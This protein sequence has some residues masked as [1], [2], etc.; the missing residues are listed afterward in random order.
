MDWSGLDSE[1]CA[2]ATVYSGAPFIHFW[3]VSQQGRPQNVPHLVARLSQ[4]LPRRLL[5]C[6][7]L[8][9]VKH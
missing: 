2:G 3:R 8:S 1:G 6:G 9:R 5:K 7:H 4:F